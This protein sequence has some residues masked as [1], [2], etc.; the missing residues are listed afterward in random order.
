LTNN[1]LIDTDIL[2]YYFK[3][4]PTVVKNFEAY[5]EESSSIEISIITYYE[6]ASGLLAKN[7]MKQL[8]IFESFTSDNFIVPLTERSCKISA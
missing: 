3:G 6:I 7:A 8:E 4:D 5:L 1:A 2:S